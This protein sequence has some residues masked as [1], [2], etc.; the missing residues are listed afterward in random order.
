MGSLLACDGPDKQPACRDSSL[1]AFIAPRGA[2][3]RDG[4][5]LYGGE[6]VAAVDRD[7]DLIPRDGDGYAMEGPWQVWVEVE[8]LG[9]FR[10]ADTGYLA[11]HGIDFDLLFA[12]YGEAIEFGRQTRRAC[13]TRE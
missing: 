2:I 11:E 1:S 10:V 13:V 7:S 3:T 6:R 4:T 9:E 5:R 8:G 12:S